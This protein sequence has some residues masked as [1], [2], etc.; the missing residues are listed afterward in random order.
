MMRIMGADVEDHL[1]V[2]HE[3]EGDTCGCPC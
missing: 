1:C 2:K 3:G